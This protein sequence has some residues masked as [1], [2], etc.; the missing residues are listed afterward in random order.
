MAT[1]EGMCCTGVSKC[2]YLYT[3]EG[4]D[5]PNCQYQGDPLPFLSLMWS[6]ECIKSFHV[7][8]LFCLSPSFPVSLGGSIGTIPPIQLA[9]FN[10]RSTFTVISILDIDTK[11]TETV[12]VHD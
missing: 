9:Q 4:S 11:I 8:T 5:P 6:L 1:T 12:C 7:V 2:V 3:S 10:L